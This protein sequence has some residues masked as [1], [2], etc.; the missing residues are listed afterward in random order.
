[1]SQPLTLADVMTPAP[2]TISASA[3]LSTAQ[4]LMAELE[5]NHLPVM[6]G[7][8]VES[9]ITDRDIKR[10][11][12]PAHKLAEDEDLLV[13]DIATTR[14]FVADKNDRL[15]PVLRQM[16]KQHSAAVVVLDQGEL[17]GIFTETDACRVLAELLTTKS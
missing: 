16:L 14:A 13:S 17:A 11:T 2:T 9:I 3:H 6:D 12:L 1:M 4:T 10:Y 8:L 7:T 15:E 5:V